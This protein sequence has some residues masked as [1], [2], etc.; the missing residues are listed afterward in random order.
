MSRLAATFGRSSWRNHTRFPRLSEII[1]PP[2]PTGLMITVIFSFGRMI[3]DGSGVMK[4]EPPLLFA[5]LVTVTFGGSSVGSDWKCSSL[6]GWV[7]GRFSTGWVA[8]SRATPN[9]QLRSRRAA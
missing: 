9:D 6:S 2:G 5:P 3:G 7:A 4:I 1:G 8:P